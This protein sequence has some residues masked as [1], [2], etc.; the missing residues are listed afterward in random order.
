M[1][2][3]SRKHFPD[4]KDCV[5]YRTV[6]YARLS[7]ENPEQEKIETQIDEIR[8]YIL[9]KPMFR[10]VNIYADN[11]Y[12]GM[13]FNRPAFQQM[14]EDLRN[15]KIDCIV[16]RDL[17]RFA[18]EHIGAEDY[19]N[20]IFPFL[21]VRFISIRDDYDNIRIEPQEYFIAS[22]K[23]FAHSY[24]AQ[25]TSRKV[26]TIKQQMQEQG[27][28]IGSKVSYGY[29]R[30]PS[31]K[32]KL[33]PEPEQAAVVHEIFSRVANGE[34]IREICNILNEK[35]AS[36]YVW[37]DSRIYAI[38]KKEIYKGT[39]V[40]RQTV[41]AMYRNEPMQRVPKEQQIR[42]ENAVPAIVSHELWQKAQNALAER[43]QKKHE[44]IPENPYSG[45]VFCNQC[46][47]KLSGGFR[48]DLQDFNFNCD[49][50]RNGVFAK[51]SHIKQALADYLKISDTT[52]ITKFFLSEKF[53]KILITNKKQIDFIEK[54]GDSE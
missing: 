42:L 9:K 12:S 19:L 15:R 2:R 40:Q 21:G 51:G 27:K 4:D 22:F 39:L 46:G 44:G 43:V 23:N 38:L 14:M 17:S 49:K 1:A 24:M 45:L 36:G 8:N 31:D 53:E 25:E 54:G 3:K 52:E 6:I 29:M 33:I 50:C 13:N 41:T 26:S 7:R 35:E 47:K 48:R 11:G 5:V 18:R 20:N 30:D 37:S 32:H 28:F 10:L 16:V 34:N